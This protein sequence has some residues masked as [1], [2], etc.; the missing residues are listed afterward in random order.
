M[1]FVT[2]LKHPLASHHIRILRDRDT[3]IEMFRRSLKGLGLFLAVEATRQL[4]AVSSPVI[5]PLDVEAPGEAVESG[6]VLLVPVLRAGLGFL[7]SFLELL[8]A[9]RVAH[10][11]VSRDHETLQACTYLSVIPQNPELFD[12]VFVLDPMLATGNSSVK[13]L[14]ILQDA[15]YSQEKIIFACG[16]AVEEGINQ[17]KSKF[18]AIGIIA[19]TIDWKLNEVGYIVPGLGDAGDRLYLI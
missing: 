10:V 5:T 4:Q 6:R 2:V 14:E 15:G 19:G 8:P 11:G 7:D 1:S 16:F 9:A 12:T 18:P 13:T 3:D 17:I